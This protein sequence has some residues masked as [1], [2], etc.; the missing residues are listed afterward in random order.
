MSLSL[1]LVLRSIPPTCDVKDVESMLSKVFEKSTLPSLSQ[2]SL[3]YSSLSSPFILPSLNVIS[4]CLLSLDKGKVRTDNT[5]KLGRAS[6]EVVIGFTSLDLSKQN[7]EILFDIP[8]V[9][10]E[11]LRHV[12]ARFDIT[13]ANAKVPDKD[14][15]MVHVQAIPAPF[16]KIIKTNLKEWSELKITYLNYLLF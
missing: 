14:G 15:H 3:S 13:S 9:R 12:L 16:Q 8:H 5:V 7:S 4:W 2:T 6:I 10:E 11:C 1:K